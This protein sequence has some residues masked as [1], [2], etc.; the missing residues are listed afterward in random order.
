[1]EAGEHSLCLLWNNTTMKHT[2]IIYNT[3]ILRRCTHVSSTH[4]LL[5]VEISFSYPSVFNLYSPTDSSE[6]GLLVSKQLTYSEMPCNLDIHF[7]RLNLHS[8]DMNYRDTLVACFLLHLLK[9]SRAN[10]HVNDELKANVSVISSV[11][12][13]RTNVTQH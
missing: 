13:V 4:Y 1:M 7:S 10:R 6:S 11:S 8:L 9:S 5:R 2:V 3:N 12:I